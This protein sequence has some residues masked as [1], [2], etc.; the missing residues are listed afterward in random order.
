MCDHGFVVRSIVATNRFL[1]RECN[2]RFAR[3]PQKVV[4]LYE[5]CERA[6]KLYNAG[7]INRINFD[8]LVEEV[9]GR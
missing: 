6:I 1:C 7:F 3:Y 5:Y 9:Y 2:E 4:K 8:E